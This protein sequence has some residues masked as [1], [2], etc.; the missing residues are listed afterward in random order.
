MYFKNN[1]NTASCKGKLYS[2]AV[3]RNGIIELDIRN[4]SLNSHDNCSPEVSGVMHQRFAHREPEV[5]LK[6]Q[7]KDLV[8]LTNIC[9]CC[10]DN[11]LCLRGKV[12]WT[13]IPIQNQR[14]S[15][16]PPEQIHTGLCGPIKQASTRNSTYLLSFTGDFSND[17]KWYLMEEKLQTEQKRRGYVAMVPKKF[18]KK[19]QV[20]QSDWW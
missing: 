18:N 5:L 4:Q 17:T 6:L 19:P 13:S 7:T 8:T 10:N 16:Q 3:L 2:T 20:I 12:T 11:Q 14:C 15:E 9:K 1:I